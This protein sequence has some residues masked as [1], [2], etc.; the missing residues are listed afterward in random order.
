MKSNKKN[1]IQDINFYLKHNNFED[2]KN[3]IL[4]KL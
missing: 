1:N 4:N 3:E 2:E